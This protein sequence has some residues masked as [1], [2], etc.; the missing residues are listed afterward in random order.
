MCYGHSTWFSVLGH[1]GHEGQAHVRPVSH[2]ATTTYPR[3]P[4]P[5]GRRRDGRARGRL[6]RRRA[7]LAAAGAANLLDRAGLR[8]SAAGGRAAGVQ[9][10]YA[11]W[12]RGQ[13]ARPVGGRAGP[14][15]GAARRADRAPSARAACRGVRRCAAARWP[16]R[17]AA[18]GAARRRRS[19]AWRDLAAGPPQPS[20]LRHARWAVAEPRP[21]P[22]GPGGRRGSRRAGGPRRLV[23]ARRQHAATSAQPLR[24]RA[25]LYRR[26]DQLP[27]A[28]HAP[29]PGRARR[30]AGGAELPQ[31]QRGRDRPRPDTDRAAGPLGRR[32]VGAAGGLHRRRSGDPRRDRLLSGDRPGLRL[33]EP[34]QPTAARRAPDRASLPGWGA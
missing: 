22:A 12:A 17:A 8:A 9:A 16:W 13:R 21:V 19:A 14:S 4:A 32:P 29:L 26:G 11:C 5:A 6:T 18:T 27:A 15:P 10:R 23:G 1:D 3:L 30:R 25:R 33:R 34:L 20:H 28:A 24:G 2:F 31:G 7:E